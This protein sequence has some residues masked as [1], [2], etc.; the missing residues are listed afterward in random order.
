MTIHC[1]SPSNLLYPAHFTNIPLTP[2]NT[3]LLYPI[4]L[5]STLTHKGPSRK[6]LQLD[7]W[8]IKIIKIIVGLLCKQLG[9][10][11][12]RNKNFVSF[13][14][15]PIE[16]GT[17]TAPPSFKK[18]FWFSHRK[19]KIFEIQFVIRKIGVQKNTPYTSLNFTPRT[20]LN[21]NPLQYSMI[22]TVFELAT[23]S[24]NSTMLTLHFC[25]VKTRQN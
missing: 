17:V 12:T 10:A 20:S 13:R 3:S 8:G 19:L 2:Q 6:C 15:K 7:F 22:I 18:K 23:L 11:R 5:H 1:H 4:H 24:L 25:S 9:T 21:Y 14:K 16:K